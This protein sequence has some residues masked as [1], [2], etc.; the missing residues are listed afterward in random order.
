MSITIYP[1]SDGEFYEEPSVNMSNANAATVFESL[2]LSL[3]PDY[4]GSLPAEDFLGR[5]LMAEAVAPEDAGV[6]AMTTMSLEGGATMIDCGRPEGYTQTRL[7]QLR[8]VAEF[9][10][11]RGA[12]VVWA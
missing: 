5:V 2:G 4:C 9:A 7:A 8:Q 3:A 6:P 12:S 11:E 10:Q 1:A